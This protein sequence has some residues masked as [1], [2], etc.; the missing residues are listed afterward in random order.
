MEMQLLEEERQREKA[1]LESA[2]EKSSEDYV[3]VLSERDAA[4]ARARDLEQQLAAARAD[5]ELGNTDRNRALLACENLQRALEAIQSERD[6][7]IALL[8]EQR[9]AAEEAMEAAHAAALEAMR[10]SNKAEMRDVQY[11]ADKS[12]QN[13]LA[14]M[15]KMEATIVVSL[16]M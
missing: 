13:S 9:T 1:L 15:D 10:E 6:A 3:L 16:C 2:K 5:V 14:E 11:A 8:M 12:V 7:E 4:K